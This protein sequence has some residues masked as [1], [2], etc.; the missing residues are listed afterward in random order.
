MLDGAIASMIRLNADARDALHDSG[1][2]HAVTDVTG[3]GLAGHAA[4]MAEGSGLTIEIDPDA[5]PI[6]DG[7]EALAIPRNF[8]RASATNRAFLHSRT[9]ID[10]GSDPRRLEFAFDA[11]TSG[12]LL[13]AVDPGHV[14]SLIEALKARGALAS[15]IVGRVV[16]RAGEIALRIGRT[17]TA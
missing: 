13:I 16:P 12:G 6:L 2:A 7:A 9:E 10:P 15:A 1:G 3:Y 14:H 8:T 5:L 11:Q 17:P 4:E